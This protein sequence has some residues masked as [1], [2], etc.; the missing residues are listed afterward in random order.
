MKKLRPYL[1]VFTVL[2]LLVVAFFSARPAYHKLKKWR[3]E[4]LASNA[5]ES[6]EEGEISKAWESAASAYE[7]VPWEEDII[8]TM[9]L[10]YEEVEPMRAYPF[11]K[12]LVEKFGG[13]LEDRRKLAEMAMANADYSIVREQLEV[14]LEEMPEDSRVKLLHARLLEA[15]KEPDLALSIVKGLVELPDATDN[16]RLFYATLAAESQIPA[17][18]EAG[19]V[20]LQEL[21]RRDDELGLRALR[22]CLSYALK[23]T[24]SLRMVSRRLLEHPL[25]S[26]RDLILGYEARAQL[27]EVS[28]KAVVNE[29]REL[30]NLSSMEDRVAWVRWLN[31]QG[32]YEEVLSTLDDMDV[33]ARKDLSLAYIEALASSG[34]WSEL[35]RVVDEQTLPVD[36]YILAV[37]QSRLALEKGQEQFAAIQWET[38]IHMAEGEPE[39]IAYLVEYARRNNLQEYRKQALQRFIS[40]P[41]APINAFKELLHL[42]QMM[43]NTEGMYEVLSVMAQRFPEDESVRNDLNYISLLLGKDMDKTVNDAEALLNKNPH[44]L[45]YKATL[46]LGYLY[47]GKPEAAMSVLE[48][49]SLKIAT[50]PARSRLLLAAVLYS[51]SSFDVSAELL[52]GIRP[53]LLLTEERAIFN[54]VSEGLERHLDNHP[55]PR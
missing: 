46:A 9:A 37:I 27:P 8:R 6:I 53:D 42:E 45:S 47:Q 26:R 15:Q 39:K 1:I 17:E 21:C 14:L 54:Q 49:L 35:E 32:Q 22:L 11:W 3:A 48:G 2:A 34:D 28:P 5:R 18:R 25:A 12:K 36:A 55:Q 20:Y 29:V 4:Q 51:N 7:L 43:G 10:V 23:D 44:Y 19:I 31:K 16:T 24:E 13:Q 30:F 52:Q 38:A 41:S 40:Q 50:M 33:F